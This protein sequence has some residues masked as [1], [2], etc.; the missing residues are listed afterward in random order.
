MEEIF[1]SEDWKALEPREVM[2]APFLEMF[3]ARLDGDE[4]Q[5][6]VVVDKP[7]SWHG[8]LELEDS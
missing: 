6:D 7:C 3:K 4:G 8:G 1:Y 5:P 2:D